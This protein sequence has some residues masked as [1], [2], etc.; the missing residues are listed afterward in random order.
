MYVCMRRTK[1]FMFTHIISLSIGT[2]N[3]S[4]YLR[5]TNLEHAVQVDPLLP[6]PAH[7]GQ[8]VGERGTLGD[9]HS[10]L[11]THVWVPLAGRTHGTC[12]WGVCTQYCER[13][14]GFIC[15][16]LCGEPRWLKSCS[17]AGIIATMTTYIEILQF[18]VRINIISLIYNHAGS[19]GDAYNKRRQVPVWALCRRRRHAHDRGDDAERLGAAVGHIPLPG[20]ELLAGFWCECCCYCFIFAV[21]EGVYILI[22]YLYEPL[23]LP[24]P[25]T[26]TTTPTN[27]LLLLTPILY[28][29]VLPL[30]QVYYQNASEGRELVWATSWGVS[31]RLIGT[32]AHPAILYYML[33][34]LWYTM[35]SVFLPVPLLILPLL[36]TQYTSSKI[37][38]YIPYTLFYPI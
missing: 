15:R 29:T 19:A 36:L 33:T 35:L 20:P 8:P 2:F 25:T 3:R 24:L 38:L 21:W 13:G 16:Y 27:M 7:E 11:P 12:N 22:L 31:T 37:Y 23:L 6:R 28:Y 18:Q 34:V 4:S 9:A 30:L 26:T 5:N 10:T 32:Y 1:P 14:V 17:F